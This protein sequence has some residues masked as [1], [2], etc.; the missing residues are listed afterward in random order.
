[1]FQYVRDL[2]Q[3]TGD[4]GLAHRHILEKFGR[5]AEKRAPAG[6]RDVRGNQNVG[7]VQVRAHGFVVKQPGKGDQ[8]PAHIRLERIPHLRSDQPVTHEKKFQLA[9]LAPGVVEQRADRLFEHGHSVPITKC[10]DE[11]DDDIARQKT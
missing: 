2:I 10:P 9:A 3:G 4:N 7:S 11:A 8:A 6:H 1:M 5:G